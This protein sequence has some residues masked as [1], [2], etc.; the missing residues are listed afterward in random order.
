MDIDFP[1]VSTNDSPFGTVLMVL[2]FFSVFDRS[3]HI[4]VLNFLYHMNAALWFLLV[5]DT[6][7]IIIVNQIGRHVTMFRMAANRE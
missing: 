4:H 7:N 3:V 6:T 5:T 2:Y 1:S